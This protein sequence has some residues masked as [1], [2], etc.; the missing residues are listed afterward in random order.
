MLIVNETTGRLE[1][2]N[3]CSVA[4]DIRD[5]TGCSFIESKNIAIKA[6]LEKE[7]SDVRIISGVSQAGMAVR[8]LTRIIEFIVQ[9]KFV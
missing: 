2:E 6:A 3:L 4:K 1:V 9:E 7:L 5:K 8:N